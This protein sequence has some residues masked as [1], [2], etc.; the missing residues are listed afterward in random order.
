MWP[1]GIPSIK[2]L[3][4]TLIRVHRQQNFTTSLP[5]Q[6][7]LLQNLK[8]PIEAM[9]VGLRPQAQ[10]TDLANW[11]RFTSVTPTTFSVPTVVTTAS[12]FSSTSTLSAAVATQDG[13]T[14]AGHTIP[15]T[16]TVTSTITPTFVEASATANVYTKTIDTLTVQAHGIALYNN[17]P[18]EFYHQYVT[19]TFGGPHIATPDD[20]GCLMIP[21]NLYPGTY[22]PSGHV[23]VSRAREFYIAYTSSVIGQ[24]VSGQSV[25]GDLTIVAS[26]INFSRLI[27]LTYGTFRVNCSNQWEIKVHA[28]TCA[29]IYKQVQITIFVDAKPSNCGKPLKL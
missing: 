9:F 18:A 16:G 25:V 8:W 7:V 22:Q 23:N 11:H 24:I 4:F 5:T 20:E 3:G 21:F 12:H 1:V 19:Y 14:T 10:K 28:K 26:A 6:D 29:S 13:T 17:L 27:Q 15:V 2:R